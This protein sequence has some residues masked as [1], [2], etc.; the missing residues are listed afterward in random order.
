MEEVSST[1]TRTKPTFLPSLVPPLLKLIQP[2]ALSF[3]PLASVSPHPPTTSVLSVIHICA[4]ECLNNI[5]LAL[6]TSEKPAIA[7]DV[8]S[9]Q[10]IWREIWTALGSVGVEFGLGQERRK[11]MWEI[12]VGVMWGVSNVWRGHIV[13][14]GSPMVISR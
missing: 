8:E 14:C 1:A 11:E 13:R 7:D 10:H 3:P 2:V 9:G 12:A 4:L 5:F 6:A